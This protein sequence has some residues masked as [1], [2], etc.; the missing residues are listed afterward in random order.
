MSVAPD[1]RTYTARETADILGIGHTT[2]CRHVKTGAADHLKP[3]V[4]GQTIHF[5]IAH[6]DDIAPPTGGEAA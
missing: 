2:L 4:V 5:P 3:I 6:I 1:R